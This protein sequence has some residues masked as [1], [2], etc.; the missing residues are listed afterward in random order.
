MGTHAFALPEGIRNISHPADDARMRAIPES[1]RR[2]EFENDAAEIGRRWQEA[3]ALTID[4]SPPDYIHC[5]PTELI[6]LIVENAGKGV[7]DIN[8]RLARPRTSEPSHR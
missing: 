1:L 6:T 5:S 8:C 3:L 4:A 7:A 2:S